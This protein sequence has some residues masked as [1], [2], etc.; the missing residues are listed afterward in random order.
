MV[1]E[2]GDGEE[3]LTPSLREAVEERVAGGEAGAEVARM[4][5]GPGWAMFNCRLDYENGVVYA[6]AGQYPELECVHFNN[7]SIPLDDDIS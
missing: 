5:L 4:D 2:L 1:W 6:I 7:I 3:K